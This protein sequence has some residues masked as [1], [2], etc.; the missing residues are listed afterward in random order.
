MLLE[1]KYQAIVK[2]AEFT[3]TYR[4]FAQIQYTS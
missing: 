2:N 1:P 3:F 4:Y